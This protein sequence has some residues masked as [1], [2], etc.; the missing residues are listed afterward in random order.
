MDWKFSLHEEKLNTLAVFQLGGYYAL[1]FISFFFVFSMNIL[2]FCFEF[3]ICMRKMETRNVFIY[4]VSFFGFV[5]IIY[6]QKL[7]T[8]MRLYV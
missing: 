3:V 7:E 1:C 5:C 6:M 4:C 2:F 8:R